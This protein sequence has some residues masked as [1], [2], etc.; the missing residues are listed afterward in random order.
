MGVTPERQQWAVDTMA[1]GPR[2]RVLEIGCGHGI[3]VSLICERLTTG[4][5][6]AIDRSASMVRLASQRNANHIAAGRAEFVAADLDA[7]DLPSGGFDKV[8][9]VNVSLFWLGT[10]PGQI[11]RVKSL[12]A[13]QGTLYVFHEPPKPSIAKT[14]LDK[15]EATLK[16]HGFTT[17]RHRATGR[18]GLPLTCVT[19]RV[20]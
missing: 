16:G 4:Q 19:G 6:T 8:F 20:G 18:R 12:L 9:A 2:D 13:H 11:E 15:A 5:V 10:G 17:A 1:I 7:A 3:A 14:I